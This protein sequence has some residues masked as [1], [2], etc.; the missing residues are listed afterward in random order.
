MKEVM[1][2]IRMNMINKTKDALLIAGY[3][4]MHVRKVMGRGK[5]KVDFS[6]LED[7]IKEDEIQSYKLMQEI[8]E[9]HRLLPKR[10]IT[11]FVN[12]EDVT[13]VVDSIIEVNRT[14]NSGDGKIFIMEADDVVRIRTG[15]RKEAAI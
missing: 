15:E 3:P 4:S 12:D 1:A 10:V 5:K 2:V 8:S 7:V 11:L 14:G 6:L 9:T 13:K